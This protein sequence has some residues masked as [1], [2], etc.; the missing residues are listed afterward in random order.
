ML[1]FDIL[2]NRAVF[3]SQWA[4]AIPHLTVNENMLKLSIT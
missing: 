1:L 2:R 3:Y 4:V